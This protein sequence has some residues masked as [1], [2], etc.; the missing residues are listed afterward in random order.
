MATAQRRRESGT[1]MRCTTRVAN[2]CRGRA[3]LSMQRQVQRQGDNCVGYSVDDA[4]TYDRCYWYSRRRPTVWCLNGQAEVRPSVATPPTRPLAMGVRTNFATVD[5][6]VFQ[7]LATG[8]TWGAP[9]GF[10][11][12]LRNLRIYGHAEAYFPQIPLT[13][14]TSYACDYDNIIAGDGASRASYDNCASVAASQQPN[15]CCAVHPHGGNARRS[16]HGTFSHLLWI[17]ARK[18][19]L[20]V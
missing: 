14:P 5:L 8:T 4:D 7:I 6:T 12:S 13:E 17:V 3:T 18:Q 15:D 9:V 1:R 11:G 20:D 16:F 19:R 2:S 10:V